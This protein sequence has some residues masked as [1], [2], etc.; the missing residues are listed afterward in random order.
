M[1]SGRNAAVG[2]AMGTALSLA[3]T[4]S[5]CGP[6]R[7]PERPAPPPPPSDAPIVVNAQA[8]GSSLLPGDVADTYTERI[9]ALLFRGLVRYD[10]KGKA[11]NE[12]A[13]SIESEDNRTF[14]V[15]LKPGWVFSNGEPITATSFVDTWNATARGTSRRRQANLFAPI[16]GYAQINP[17]D[18]SAPAATVLSGLS[19]IDPLHFT[20]TLSTPR[21]D[22]VARLGHVG[23][24]PLPSQALRDPAGF[25]AQPVGNGPYLLERNW[26]PAGELTLRPNSRYVGQDR[27]RNAGLVFRVYPSLDRAH[28]DFMDGR[29]DI[30]DVMPTAALPTYKTELKLRAINQPVG[31]VQ[32]LA[33]PMAQPQWQSVRGRRLRAAISMAINRTSLETTVFG[34]TRRAATDFAAPVVEG[35]ASDL[36]TKTCQFDP[37]AAAAAL[38]EAGGPAGQT[39]MIGYALDDDDLPWVNAVCTSITQTLGLGCL[40]SAYPTQAALTKAVASRNHTGPFVQTTRME[41]ASLGGFLDPRFVVGAPANDVG[42]PDKRLQV[43]LSA[44]AT[45]PAAAGVA[46][47]QDV[48]RRLLIDLPVIPLWSRNATGGFAQSVTNVKMDVF[49]V[50]IYTEVTRP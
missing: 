9:A 13:E 10:A 8:P 36:C 33:F 44:A 42:Y 4:L 25:A 12:I 39:L 27:A 5:G 40:P 45:L 14:T 24:A 50:P 35:H 49:G 43:M 28:A 26:T 21:P 22:F 47:Y 48:E 38:T 20:I 6:A 17:A 30:L 16:A 7:E 31:V 32:S 3:L 41:V 29:L 37:E 15:A 23:F 11:I 1:R 2:L 34:G 19:V 18:P 46:A